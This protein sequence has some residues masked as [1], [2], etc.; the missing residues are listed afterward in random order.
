MGP[1]G[2]EM[3]DSVIDWSKLFIG[4]DS[5]SLHSCVIQS[6]YVAKK[7]SFHLQ[8]I[9]W[10]REQLTN[11]NVSLVLVN[12]KKNKMKKKQQSARALFKNKIIYLQLI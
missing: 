8:G 4:G 11:D 1:K 3:I 7:L 12:Q 2:S 5:N 6:S 9:L 10:T